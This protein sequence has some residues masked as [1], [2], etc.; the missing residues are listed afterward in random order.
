MHLRSKLPSES[1]VVIDSQLSSIP[2]VCLHT[3]VQFLVRMPTNT[4]TSPVTF[5]FHQTTI[6]SVSFHSSKYLTV[7]L[8]SNTSTFHP[9]LQTPSFTPFLPASALYLSEKMPSWSDSERNK[10]FL[11]MIELMA[12]HGSNNKLPSW[13]LVAER[14]QSGFTG[15]AVRY[16]CFFPPTCHKSAFSYTQRVFR[17]LHLTSIN[18]KLRIILP[19]TAIP[20]MPKRGPAP[21]YTSTE[22]FWEDFL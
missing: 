11:A 9:I 1:L 5:S 19:Q 20:K 8:S 10:M 4:D 17:P 18:C 3:T 14:M 22:L 13:T 2:F 16:I 7:Y 12:P 15:E 21:K 6:F